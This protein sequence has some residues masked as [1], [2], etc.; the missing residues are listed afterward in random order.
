MIK[1]S[2][3]H[4]PARWNYP[5]EA[6]L[7]SFSSKEYKD[8]NE[9]E[10][11]LNSAI[12]RFRV[13][14]R[15]YLLDLNKVLRSWFNPSITLSIEV[16]G[17]E[18]EYLRKTLHHMAKRHPNVGIINVANK[19]DEDPLVVRL[20]EL[21]QTR[22][23]E[24]YRRS[25][26]IRTMLF[27]SAAFAI[28][29]AMALAPIW[30]VLHTL[31]EMALSRLIIAARQWYLDSAAK[32]YSKKSQIN[33]IDNHRVLTALEKGAKSV[34]WGRYVLSHFSYSAWRHP[35]AFAAGLEL[36]LEEKQK[37]IQLIHERYTAPRPS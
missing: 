17:V 11:E 16:D 1:Y 28:Y 29:N 30:I 36:G 23:K 4:T 5:I 31:K 19:T 12:S 35:R 21:V 22:D 27:I 33:A 18:P 34:G 24:V 26:Q 10:A 15:D 14:W 6:S 3:V 9:L 25:K 37:H 13:T 7:T 2:I 8:Q 20:K 32:H